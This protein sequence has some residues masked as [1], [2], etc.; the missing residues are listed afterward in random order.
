[1]WAILY[2]RFDAVV[3]LAER[4]ADLSMVDIDGWNLLHVA[5]IGGD[6]RCINW[7]LANSNIDINSTTNIGNTL[8]N[9][10]LFY[11]NLDAGKLLVEKGANL[12]KKNDDGESAMDQPMGPQVLEHA[13]NM[14]WQSVKPLLL[15]S[16]SF[17]TNAP[18]FDPSLATLPSVIKVLSNSHLVREE[19]APFFRWTDII[20]RDPVIDAEQKANKAKRRTEEAYAAAATSS[21]SSSNKRGRED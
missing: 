5:S 15:L 11:E 6:C 10:A 17:S 21:S 9:C 20:I 7:V 16:T 4:G 13:K 8:I 2:C 19:I 12:F 1:M 18:P 3:M 14:V